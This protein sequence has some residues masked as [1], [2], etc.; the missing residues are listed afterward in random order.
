MVYNGLG[1]T[2]FQ[3]GKKWYPKAMDYH[4]KSLSLLIAK[5]DPEHPC[6]EAGQALEVG[7]A[8]D[9][10][11]NIYFSE[12]KNDLAFQNYH[13][14]IAITEEVRFSTEVI[15]QV[16][17]PGMVREL[18]RYQMHLCSNTGRCAGTT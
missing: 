16:G 1:S 11:A 14:A 13:K 5:E 15:Y 9:G 18:Y 3:M 2:Y 17:F 4:K 12:E 6:L 10:M 8:Y 7:S